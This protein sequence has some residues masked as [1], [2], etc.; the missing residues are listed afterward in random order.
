[1]NFS[2]M[3]LICGIALTAMTAAGLSHWWSL[4][5]MNVAPHPTAS[6]APKKIEE[7]SVEPPPI[8]SELTTQATP[9]TAVVVNSPVAEAPGQ[10]QFYEKMLERMEGLQNQNA[11][12]LNQLAE[13]NRDVM[14][15]EFRVDT[16]SE[17][18]RPLPV[19]EDKPFT[20]F[21]NDLGVLPP[22]AEPVQLPDLE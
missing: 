19:S 22:R 17:S 12:L 1:M 16:H 15:L 3:P 7:L 11:D 2:N 5:Q 18:F 13:T 6:D 10:M 8:P 14:K 4:R 9:Q 21:D 20:S